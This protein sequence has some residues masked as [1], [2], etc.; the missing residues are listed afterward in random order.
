L[1]QNKKK[2]SAKEGPQTGTIVMQMR[3]YKVNQ[4]IPNSKFKTN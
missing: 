3:N 1:H 4:G 2:I